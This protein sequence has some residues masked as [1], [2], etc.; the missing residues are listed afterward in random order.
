MLIWSANKKFPE[1]LYTELINRIHENYKDKEKFFSSYYQPGE[2]F[3]DIIVPYYGNVIEEIMKDL[4]IWSR[5]KYRYNLWVQMYNS[6][7]TTHPPHEHFTGAE[8]ISF[9][10]IIDASNNKCFY[11]LND[12]GDKIYPEHQER[13]DIFAWPPWRRHGVDKVQ[14]PNVNR[15]IVA[16]NIWLDS[17]VKSPPPDDVYNAMVRTL[18]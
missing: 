1:N 14:E 4:G 13:G 6:E 5:T 7:T 10:H 12:N 17:Y 11:F 8:I 15:L 3:S 16:G 18:N 2:I 9:N